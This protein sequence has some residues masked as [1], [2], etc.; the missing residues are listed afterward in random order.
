MSGCVR[1]VMLLFYSM[2]I[3]HFFV[4]DSRLRFHV[5]RN[6]VCRFR[7]DALQ[8]CFRKALFPNCYTLTISVY[9]PYSGLR[10][11]LQGRQSSNLFHYSHKCIFCALLTSTLSKQPLQTSRASHSVHYLL[12]LTLYSLNRAHDS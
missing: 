3:V 1:S 10:L 7:P 5:V 11:S 6:C 9:I 4:P 2:I 12:A 8:V